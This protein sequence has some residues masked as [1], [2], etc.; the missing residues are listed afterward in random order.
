MIPLVVLIFVLGVYPTPTVLNRINPSV[1]TV[2]AQAE[3]TYVDPF[4]TPLVAP[5]TAAL[6]PRV[7][8]VPAQP[9]GLN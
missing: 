9:K 4:K 7:A 3:A 1:N 8:A 2:M 5:R 6:T